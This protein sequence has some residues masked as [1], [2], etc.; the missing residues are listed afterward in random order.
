MPVDSLFQKFSDLWMAGY[1]YGLFYGLL[2][3]F[4]IG[5]L[6]YVAAK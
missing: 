4:C 3:G 5:I 1:Q 6:G 2:L